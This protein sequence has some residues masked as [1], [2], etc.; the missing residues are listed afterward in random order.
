M[1]ADVAHATDDHLEDGATVAAQQ[2]DL[3]K[4]DECHVP[5]VR[6]VLPVARDTVPLLRRGAEDVR[7]IQ[8]GDVRLGIAREL[9]HGVAQPLLKPALPILQ[10]FLH[11]GFQGG[12]VDY[13]LAR[14]QGE[15][16]KQRE[17]R[18]DS[19]PGARRGA[20]QGIHVS[21]VQVVED[22]RLHRVEVREA[23]QLH[24]LVGVEGGGREWVQRQQLR[25]RWVRQG[26]DQVLE[27]E[28]HHLLRTEKLLTDDPDHVLAGHWV[29]QRDRE[30]DLLDLALLDGLLRQ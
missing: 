30:I 28:R 13:L 14:V 19:L 6:P 15:D 8:Q 16:A 5:H 10:P 1:P 24:E 27:G 11:Q 12:N 22:L 3:I 18:G 23:V 4:D 25:V 7:R 29:R 21:V 2:M 20:D 26:E 9:H 17:L